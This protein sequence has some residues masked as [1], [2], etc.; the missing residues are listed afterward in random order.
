MKVSTKTTNILANVLLFTMLHVSASANGFA[1]RLFEQLRNSFNCHVEAAQMAFMPPPSCLFLTNTNLDT[2]LSGWTTSGAAST[3]DAY[4][5]G[6]AAELTS[7]WATMVQSSTSAVADRV[8]TLTAYAKRESSPSWAALIIRFYNNTGTEL[9]ETSVSVTTTSYTEYKVSA[10]APSGVASIKIEIEKSGSG[11]LKVD[12]LCLEETTPA[13]GQCILVENAGFESQLTGWSNWNG[14]VAA[15]TDKYA[16]TYAGQISGDGTSLYSQFAI[17]AGE[18]YQLTAWAKTSGSPSWAEIYLVWKDVSNNS[19]SDIIHPVLAST[20][21]YTQFTLTGKAPSNA[22]YAEIGGYKQGAGSSLF[23]DEL[24]FSVTNPLGGT[25]FDLSCGCGQNLVPNGGYESSTVTNF[26]ITLDGRPAATILKDDGNKLTPWR[27]ETTSPHIFYI[28]DIPNQVNNPEGDY[29]VWLPNSG[30][31]WTSYTDLSNNLLLEDGETYRFCFY[32]ASRVLPLDANAMPTT[33]SPVQTAGMLKLEFN[34]V[35]GFK[36][37]YEW[38]VPASESATNLSWTKF[39]Y[40]FTYN[41]LDPMSTYVFTNSRSNVGMYIDAVSLARVSCPAEKGC[42]TGGIT[43]ERWGGITGTNTDNLVANANYPNNYNET[44]F[45]TSFQSP[46]DYSNDYG[47]RAYGYLIPPAT[48]NYTFTVT[49]GDASKLYLSTSANSLNK[50]LIAQVTGNT[51]IAEYSKYSGQTSTAISLTANQ[52]YYI[53]LV[54]KAGSINSDHFQVYWQT[55][56]NSTRTIIP[57]SAL[58]PIC[59]EEVCDNGRDDDFDNLADCADPDCSSGMSGAYSVSDEACGVANGSITMMPTGGDTPYSYQWSDMPVGA[60]WTFEDDTNDKSGNGKHNNGITGYPIYLGDAAQG[61]KSGYFNGSTM[62]RYS[63]DGGF[64]EVSTSKLSVSMWIKPENLTGIKTLF[65]EGGSSNSSGIGIAMQLNGNKL[66]AGVKTS[67]TSTVYKTGQLTFPADGAWHHVAMTFNSGVIRVYLDGTGSTTNTANFSTIPAHSNNGGVAG[68]QSGSVL[69]SSTNYYKGRMDDIRYFSNT[70]LT[71]NQ[72]ANLAA[73]NGIRNNLSAGTYGVTVSSASGCSITQSVVI[74]SGGNFTNGGTIVGEETGCGSSYDPALITSSALPSPGSGTIEY[75]WQVSSNGGSTWTDISGATSATYDP[76]SI[77]ADR[78]YRRAAR[79]LPC[80]G[81]VYSNT[82]TKSF[83]TNFVGGGTIAADE[84]FCGFYDPAIINGSLPLRGGDVTFKIDPPVSG[85]S[86]GATYNITYSGGEPMFLTVTGATVTQ[87]EVKGGPASTIYTTPPFNNLTSPVNPSNGTPY[88][89]SHFNIWVSGGA[90]TTGTTEYQWHRSINGGTTWEAIPNSNVKDYDPPMLTQTTT[91]RRGAR[92]AECAS[93][94]QPANPY[95]LEFCSYNINLVVGESFNLRDYVHYKDY[96][97]IPIDWSKVFFTYTAVGANHPTTPADWNLANFNSGNFVTL[98]AADATNPG[99][100]GAGQYRIYIYRQGQSAYDDHAEIRVTT[101]GAS[102]LTAARCTGINESWKYSNN[103][104][105]TVELNVTDAGL[106][107]GDEDNCGSFDPGVISSVTTPSGGAGSTL[108]YQWQLSNDGGVT[109]TDVNGA[110]TATLDPITITQTTRYRRGA[111]RSTCS[112]FVYSNVVVKMVAAN[113][114]NAG[115]ISGAESACASFDPALITSG[116][117]PSGGTDGYTAYRWQLSTDEGATWTDISG[118]NATEY[119]PPS[120]ITTTTWYRRQTRRTPCTAWINSNTVIKEVK[121][122]PVA[123]LLQSPTTTNGYLCE[124]VNYN[125]QAMDAGAGATYSWSFG[126]YGSPASATG[127][128]PHTVSFNVPNSAASTTVTVQ[129]TVTKNGCSNVFN[130]NYNIR[131]PFTINSVNRTNPTSCTTANGSITV[132]ATPPSGATLEASIN[133]TTWINSP[134]TFSNLGPGNYNIWVRY[135]GDECMVWWGDQILEEAVNPNPYFTYWNTSSTCV[136]MSFVVQGA[137]ASG[138]TVTWDFGPGAVPATG[139]GLGPH[140]VYYTTGGVKTMRISATRFGC[141]AYEERDFTVISNYTDPGTIGADETLCANGVPSTMTTAIPP[142]GHYGGSVQ[143]Q[144][145]SRMLL[146]TVWSAWAT[147]SGATSASYSPPSISV[148]MEFRRRIRR[149][150][151]GTWLTSNVVSKFVTQTPVPTSDN[152][153]NA[154]PGFVFVGYVGTNDANLDNPIFSIESQPSNGFLDMD[155]DGEFYYIPNTTF[156]G[157][158]QFTYR[159]CNSTTGCCASATA[160][161]DM[162]DAQSPVL[163]NIPDDLEVHCDEDIPLPPVVDAF[164]NCGSVWL[165]FDQTATQGADSCSIYSYLLTRVWTASDYCGNSV[166]DHQVIT[167]KDETSPDIYRIYTLPNGKRLVAGVMENVTHRWKTISFPLQFT[168]PPVVLAQTTTKADGSAVAT[169]LRN[170]STS[171]FQLRLQEEENNDGNHSEESVAWIAIE[172]GAI[173]QGMPF[174]AGTKLATHLAASLSF[175]QGYAEPNFLGQI[176]TFNENN[177]VSLRYNSLA[178]SGVNIYCQEE[179]SFDGETNHGFETVGYIT[180]NGG[181]NLRTKDGELFGEAGSVDIDHNFQTIPLSHGYHNPIVVFGGIPLADGSP[182]TIRVKNVTPSSFQVQIDEWD[183]LDG[184]HALEKLS[185]FVVEGSIPFNKEVECSEVPDKPII[186]VEIVAMDNCDNSTPLVIEDSNWNYDC[187]SDTT[188]TRT[189]YVR[190]ECGNETQLRQ[191]FILRDTTPPTFSVPADITI[192]CDDS[193][194][195][196]TITGDVVNES[197][198]CATNLQ[199]V[200]T[201]NLAYQTGCSGYVLRL[202][203]VTDYCGNSVTKTQ[204]I[205]Y[206]TANDTD[207][208]GVTD[209]YDLD[210]DNDGIPDIIEGTGDFDGDGVPNYKDLDCDNDGITDL[211]E[212]G[213]NDRDGDGK[214]DNALTNNWD[215]DED[216]YAYGYDGN[217]NNEEISFSITFTLVG[218]DADNDGAP[219]WADRDSDNDGIPDLIEAGGADEDGNGIIDYPAPTDATTMQDSDSDGYASV[220]DPDEDTTP[221][222]E[223]PANP[224]ITKDGTEYSSGDSRVNPDFDEDGVPNIHDLDADNDGIADLVELGGVDE[225]GDGRIDPAYFVDSNFDGFF[226]LYVTYSLVRTEG[227]GTV[228]DGRAEDLNNDGS[229]MVIGDPDRDNMLNSNDFDDDGDGISDLDELRLGTHDQNDDGMFDNFVDNN[230][231]G[232]HDAIALTRI[233]YTDP[234]GILQNGQPEDDSDAGTTPYNST[235]PDGTF[236]QTNS[237][238]D[239]DDDGDG[240]LNF[241]DHDSDNDLIP[242]FHEDRNTNGIVEPGETDPLNSDTD[243]DGLPD[244]TEDTNQNGIYDQGE[245]SPLAEDTDGDLLMDGQEDVNFNGIF[246]ANESDPRN[247]CNP[248]L[249]DNCIGISL[250]VKALLHGPMLKNNNT[251]LMRDDLRSKGFL[252]TQEPYKNFNLFRLANE[253]GTE[254]TADSILERTGQQAIVDWVLVELRHSSKPDSIVATRSALLQRDGRVINPDGDSILHFRLV[255]SDEYYVALRHR[256]HLGV[257]TEDKFLLSPDPVLIDFTDPNLQVKGENSRVVMPGGKMALW[258]GDFNNNRQVVYQGPYNDIL[259]LFF[260]VVLHEDNSQILAN[261]IS[262]GYVITDF[263]LDGT[264]IYQGPNNDRSPMLI[265]TTLSNPGNANYFANYLVADKLPE[266]SLPSAAPKCGDNKTV[267]TCDFDDDGLIND[268]DYDDDND[269]V[270]DVDDSNPFNPLSDSDADGIKDAIETGGDGRYDP[271]YDSNPLE[272]DSDGDGLR[273][274][275]EDANKNGIK[276]PNESDPLDRCS[277]DS[278]TT[279]C[280]FDGDGIINAFDLDDDQDG[281]SDP[282]DDDDFNKN[283][284]S[285]GDGISDNVETGND[286]VYN[287]ATD[288]NPLNACDPNPIVGSI[289]ACN[290]VDADGDGFFGNYPPSHQL[291]DQHDNNPCFPNSTGSACPCAD[292]DGDGKILICQYPG[293][294]DQK[295]KNIALWLWTIYFT[296]GATCGP[297]QN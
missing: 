177:P 269:G 184:T 25:N 95:E 174:E 237:N 57:G 16:G 130:T 213:Y 157:G 35:S 262:Q 254:Y 22:V 3:T 260:H 148:P 182:A 230:R 153:S 287:A 280:D 81:W 140:T 66:E 137:A 282:N 32:A 8:Y 47:T 212:A 132:N 133:G 20:T 291:F 227:D 217:D 9:S 17:K 74:N 264:S 75:K 143:Y 274:G 277:P 6:R 231:D 229:V 205:R 79:L 120:T 102:D 127:P 176:Q 37:A 27:V 97:G 101:A 241:L 154:C 19:I 30:D 33:G 240:I 246:D 1:T 48:G 105:K 216:G 146:G 292:T 11:K 171:Q 204:I 288:S 139:S 163:H 238:A 180:F 203:T 52:P 266:T 158:D 78:S 209:D 131:P 211:I 62:I 208:D 43:F 160:S 293:T 13:I 156:C 23:L 4:A 119:D 121:Q 152:F 271:E 36:S 166:I 186:G 107:V 69:S 68:S 162:S 46:Q 239:V 149:S 38:A 18:T 289:G 228:L 243:G 70:A 103:V 51:G 270:F 234:D 110:T 147:I 215:V 245:T 92:I 61:N 100:T 165:S 278:K 255:R 56:S 112:G 138:S 113:F 106:I 118:A 225:N 190:D 116:S 178:N 94:G 284:D 85:T 164:E 197:D 82:I 194:D 248:L 58:R 12:E 283:S 189:F 41:I 242:D 285:D 29:Y 179:Q 99:N 199:A 7:S 198:N 71:A 202:W 134:F 108:I 45:L 222:A 124:A 161:I 232:F 93:E 187:E 233:I 126:T 196:L 104:T 76:T 88:A 259:T 206:I 268:L 261:Y 64:M 214:V 96:P 128:G 142:S 98:T 265:H 5:G 2:N 172:P 169:R 28:K 251:G 192:T 290:P 65:E 221:G 21:N 175:F 111:R 63:V 195:N 117:L 258:A 188:L 253:G 173:T 219:N 257:S 263:D 122:V 49:S 168:V 236:G 145:E 207:G 136:G 73:N 34:Y 80:T 226:D 201:D 125:F 191:T 256:N 295:T 281:V 150:P 200:Y 167:I 24:C 90:N 40:T 42:N 59:T 123:T 77:S 294:P 297:C 44:G 273:D 141:T 279:F 144:W 72:I 89:I 276:D 54:H 87:V 84:S 249:S 135:S 220:Y 129:L 218:R 53:E 50:S 67:G 224:L 86:N 275:V 296:Q 223:E 210:S 183:Y 83:S 252:P 267:P 272:Q 15:S 60:W 159:V 151:C 181:G 55:P 10:T 185:Y 26:P 91:Y 247:P 14:S 155:V 31:C 115:S 39:E 193:K 250:K 109:W 286:G 235:V 170:V 244:G 114:T